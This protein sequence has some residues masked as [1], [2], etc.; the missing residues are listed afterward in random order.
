MRRF[1]IIPSGGSGKRS[2]S[3]EPKQYLKFN[4]KELIAYTLDA[5]QNSRLIDDIII[6]AQ[7]EYFDLLE[8]IK[9]K[10]HFTKIMNIVEGGQER[11]DSVF[12]ALKSIVAENKDIVAVH[13]AARPLL[14]QNS[15]ESSILAAEK[16]GAAVVAIKAKDTLLRGNGIVTDFVDRSNIYYAQTP[17]VFEYKILYD[18]LVKAQN[19]NLKGTDESTIVK[20]FGNEVRIVDGSAF[21]FKI[22][23]QD[24]IELFRM[25]S[26]SI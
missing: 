11:Q 8:E 1:A 4:G 3:A 12:N 13:D 7:P 15:L 24:D 2:G 14:P 10:Y 17:Q 16:Y 26:N 19:E 25:I 9:L 22:T 21:N 5:F 6:S 18:A 23:T 20:H